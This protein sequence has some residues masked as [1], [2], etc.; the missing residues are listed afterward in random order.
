MVF[1]ELTTFI[2]SYRRSVWTRNHHIHYSCLHS[3]SHS[4]AIRGRGCSASLC[5][6]LP[7]RC[8]GL[9][10]QHLARPLRLNSSDTTR[11]SKSAL[12]GSGQYSKG[13]QAKQCRID[14]LVV[15]HFPRQIGIP[16]LLSP[17]HRPLAESENM[18][19]VRRGIHHPSWLGLSCCLLVDLPILYPP[20][21]N[22]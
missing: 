5:R 15:C 2:G 3:S 17:A 20:G 11:R 6:H 7:M 9:G 10:L 19:V 13:F 16:L 12:R 22:V 18:V 14:P 21:S 1:Q 4:K 8:N